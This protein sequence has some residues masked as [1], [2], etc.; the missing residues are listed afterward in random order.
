MLG[1]HTQTSIENIS[2]D[3]NIFL[4]IEALFILTIYDIQILLFW[5]ISIAILFYGL[6]NYH[7]FSDLKLY[8]Y[9]FLIVPLGQGSG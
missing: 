5:F 3:K 4:R 7:K 9:I 6:T 1:S 8:I 2:E